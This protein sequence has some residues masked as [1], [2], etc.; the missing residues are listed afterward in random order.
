MANHPVIDLIIARKK[1][2]SKP[3]QRSDEH[4]IG[5][6]IEGGGIRGSVSAG[7]VAALDY[8][9]LR[10][11]FDAVY[12]TSAGAF[13]GAYFLSDQAAFGTT[14]YYEDINQPEFASLARLPSL[15]FQSLNPVM[16]MDYLIDEVA[17]KRKYLNTQAVMDSPIPLQVIVSSVAKGQVDRLSDFS[18]SP[19]LLNALKASACIPLLAGQPIET[20]GDRYFD[21]GLFESVPYASAVEDGCTH[22]LA[23][24]T[25]PKMILRGTLSRMDKMFGLPYLRKFNPLLADQLERRPREYKECIEMLEERSLNAAPGPYVYAIQPDSSEKPVSR[26]AKNREAIVRSVVSGMKAAVGVFGGIDPNVIEVLR[27]F[28]ECGSSLPSLQ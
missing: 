11:C 21:G 6:A 3:G 14:I 5:L 22:V 12:G 16:C 25:R 2:E 4:K 13:N 28:G 18:S 17:S 8:M 23:L 15:L 9:G 7:M 24:L 19:D 1:Q 10:N 20:R 27:P 26:L